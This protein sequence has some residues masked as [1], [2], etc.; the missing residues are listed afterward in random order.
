MKIVQMGLFGD[1]YP[2]EPK[3]K[4]DKPV[5]YYKR[6]KRE[7]NYHWAEDGDPR[8]CG[9]CRWF[10][11][12]EHHVKRYFKCLLMGASRSEASDIRKNRVCE[13]WE[14]QKSQKE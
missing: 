6:W 9:S 14:E 7:H 4:R 3:T 13:N 8:R 11:V 10:A 2:P 1:E 5:G 12:S